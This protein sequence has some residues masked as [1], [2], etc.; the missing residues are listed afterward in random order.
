[1]VLHR[2][3][4]PDRRTRTLLLIA[5]VGGV[6]NGVLRIVWYTMS[7]WNSTQWPGGVPWMWR[8]ESIMHA[9][10]AMILMV[11]AF[12]T[13]RGLWIH[14]NDDRAGLW[15]RK[16]LVVLLGYSLLTFLTSATFDVLQWLGYY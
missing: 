6:G 4:R 5:D 13:T 14:R 12:I 9:T 15:V 10:L 7:L 8:T 2:P 11:C 16:L 3:D 1:M